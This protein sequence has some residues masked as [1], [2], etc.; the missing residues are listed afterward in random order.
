VILNIAFN[1]AAQGFSEQEDTDMPLKVN[2]EVRFTRPEAA[3]RLGIS[4]PTLDRELARKR[5]ECYQ[6]YPYGRVTFSEAQLQAYIEKCR[7]PARVE[8][9]A[10]A[11]A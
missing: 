6:P 7:R 1:S 11:A 5:I 8:E 3:R 9:T 2:G 10:Q 4:V